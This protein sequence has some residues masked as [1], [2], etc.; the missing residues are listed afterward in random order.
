MRLPL[1]SLTLLA[2][3]LPLCAGTG[4][5][6]A[7]LIVD[8]ANP[9]S[10]RVANYYVEKRDIPRGNVLY[11]NPAPSPGT[12]AVSHA[13]Q[14]PAFL[15]ML[16]QLGLADHID[17]VI[18]PSGSYYSMNSSGTINDACYPV[19]RFALTTPYI[20]ARQ[21]A[22]LLTNIDSSYPHQY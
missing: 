4:S 22:T 5:E 20:L 9:E 16:D 19:G 6:N 10:L 14:E 2:L 15:G 7:I 21:G 18:L 1:A 12:F 13:L 11:M 8:P 3:G 17:C